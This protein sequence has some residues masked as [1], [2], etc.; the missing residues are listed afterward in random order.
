MSAA[1]VVVFNERGEA[2]IL[3]RSPDDEWKP[4]YWDLPGGVAEAREKPEDAAYRECYE[5]T[6]IYPHD[7]VYVC[8]RRVPGFG[9]LTTFM[10]FTSFSGGIKLDHEH[11]NYMW[12][13][14]STIKFFDYIPHTEDSL[15]RAFD[16]YDKDS[17]L[18]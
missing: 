13:D 2:L 4:G 10:T 1:N 5:E 14:R 18:V 3:K 12:V 15:L 16:M 6:N 7:L 17:S 9:Q 8:Q 11:E